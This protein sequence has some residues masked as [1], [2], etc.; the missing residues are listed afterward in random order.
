ME[1][2]LILGTIVFLTGLCIGSF[3]NVLIY[4]IPLQLQNSWSNDARDFLGLA[5]DDSRDK[6][7]L[8]IAF[9][10]SHCPKCGVALKPWHNI[11][12]LSYIYLKG[13]CA[14]CNGAISPQYPLIEIIS[15]LLALF[16]Y[17][18]LGLTVAGALVFV[19][20]LTL[21][22]LTCIDIKTQL[23]PDILTYPLLWLGLLAN[24][25]NLF[26]DLKSAVIGAIAGY[27]ALWSVY[28]LFKLFTGKEG[29]GH[30]DFKLLAALGA[31]MGW[32]MLP[33][34]ILLS[35]FAGAI[36]GMTLILALGRDRQLPLAFG[37]YLALA[38]WGAF[39]WGD[40]LV[41]AYLGYVN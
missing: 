7:K 34:I 21:L 3:L 5:A 33:V 22:T 10:A 15:A 11:P 16:L 26:T 37:P 1:N 31:W 35:S 30:G 29:M 32:Q 27:L 24:T 6:D 17:L 18:Y 13:R 19:F 12:V 41:S 39:F 20:S 25:C 40:N 28:W 36:I 38:G 8:N 9:P 23:L 4:R 14:S 2:S